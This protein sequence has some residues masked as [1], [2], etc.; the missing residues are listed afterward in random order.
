MDRYSLAIK[1]LMKYLKK[2]DDVMFEGI[3]V[4]RMEWLKSIL[5]VNNQILLGKKFRVFNDRSLEIP[6]VFRDE[7]FDQFLVA[8]GQRQIYPYDI[9]DNQSRSFNAAG[10]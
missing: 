9:L 7:E 8:L 2:E 5:A 1:H 10:L 4:K 3:R 6:F